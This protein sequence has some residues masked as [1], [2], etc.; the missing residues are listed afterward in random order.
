MVSR[1]TTRAVNKSIDSLGRAIKGATSTIYRATLAQAARGKTD[2]IKIHLNKATTL[3]NKDKTVKMNDFTGKVLTKLAQQLD[4]ANTFSIRTGIIPLSDSI[5]VSEGFSMEKDST[6][7][8]SISSRAFSQTLSGILTSAN[9]TADD[10][11]GISFEI[12]GSASGELPTAFLYELDDYVYTIEGVAPWKDDFVYI[13]SFKP[14]HNLFGGNQGRYTGTL[15]I[16]TDTYAVVKETYQLAPGEHGSKFNMKFLLGIKYVE[17]GNSGTV[18]FQKTDAGS[19]FP[20]YIRMSGNRYAYFSR[21]F[22]LK[23]ND[24]N[25]QDRIK[26]K[27]DITFE[28]NTAYQDEWLFVDTKKISDK[29]FEQ[30]KANDG[31]INQQLEHYNPDVWKDYNTIAPTEAIKNYTF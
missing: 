29:A 31:V 8:D 12:G 26:L 14:D 10:S 30:F 9:L 3:I 1:K 18:I 25:R 2:S 17:K 15:Y 11:W 4:T 21:N 24:E 19:Y 6:A 7:T 22:V 16:S 20:K 13:I 5:D 28:A 23:E 27:F